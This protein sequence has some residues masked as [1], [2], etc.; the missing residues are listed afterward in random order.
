MTDDEG[1]SPLLYPSKLNIV[2]ISRYLYLILLNVYSWEKFEPLLQARRMAIISYFTVCWYWLWNLFIRSPVSPWLSCRPWC[3]YTQRKWKRRW[4][5]RRCVFPWLNILG[6]L[7]TALAIL[8]ADAKM[9]TGGVSLLRTGPA[10]TYRLY[11]VAEYPQAV[12]ETSS[13]GCSPYGTP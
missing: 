7:T 4:A 2:R 8:C 5:K 9:I 1:V 10:V 13:E 11:F 6:T 12:G 3:I